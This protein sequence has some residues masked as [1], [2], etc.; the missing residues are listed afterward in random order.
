MNK[1]NLAMFLPFLILVLVLLHSTIA[2]A[3]RIVLN[4]G[5][6]QV[7]LLELFTSQGCSSCPPAD[8]WL[9]EFVEDEDLWSGIVPLA[10]HV[11][12]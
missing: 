10:F 6:H 9:N 7:T 8:R 12:Y 5:P 3:G 2:L 11:D 4:S 1:G